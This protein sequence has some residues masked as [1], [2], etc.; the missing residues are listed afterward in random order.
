MAAVLGSG[1]DDCVR[2]GAPVELLARVRAVVRRSNAHDRLL[3]S[4][5]FGGDVVLKPL[6]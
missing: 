1:A 6:S 3:L 4:Y 5:G 2:V